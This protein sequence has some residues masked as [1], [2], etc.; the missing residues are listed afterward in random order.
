MRACGA[1]F[2]LGG[3]L[4]GILLLIVG[5]GHLTAIVLFWGIG[6][7]FCCL[8]ALGLMILQYADNI[9][10]GKPL[11]VARAARDLRLLRALGGL[12]ILLLFLIACALGE[13]DP[14]LP[15]IVIAAAIVFWG[16]LVVSGILLGRLEREA[17]KGPPPAAAPDAPLKSE[18]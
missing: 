15:C 12:G 8:G 16:P 6:G 13:G 18:P 11:A 4:P 2:V 14:A 17:S 9:A 5:F 3:F 10:R 1:E 7:F